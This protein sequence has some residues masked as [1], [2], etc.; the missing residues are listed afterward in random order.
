MIVIVVVVVVVAT[1]TEIA[2]VSTVIEIVTAVDTGPVEFDV[3]MPA[4]DIVLPMTRSRDGSSSNGL[5]GCQ[6]GWWYAEICQTRKWVN[7]PWPKLCTSSTCHCLGNRVPHSPGRSVN[8]VGYNCRMKHFQLTT[9][10][11]EIGDP[12]RLAVH[13]KA[14]FDCTMF[15]PSV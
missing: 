11:S 14:D 7:H 13:Q 10:H 1:P 6:F 8:S 15:T 5:G 4:N 2:G 9:A 12:N 3:G